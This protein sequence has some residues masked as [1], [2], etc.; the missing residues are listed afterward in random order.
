MN[1]KLAT[2]LTMKTRYLRRIYRKPCKIGNRLIEYRQPI[3]LFDRPS[4]MEI[5]LYWYQNKNGSMW[6][7]DLTDHLM[8]GLETVIAISTLTYVIETNLY[9]LHPMNE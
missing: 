4:K 6:I 3:D 7:Y 9:E 5:R 2:T 8:V 1:S